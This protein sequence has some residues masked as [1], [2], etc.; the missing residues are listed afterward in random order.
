MRKRTLGF[1]RVGL[2]AY[3]QHAAL[4]HGVAG[5]GAEIHCDL[6]QLR[7]VSDDVNGR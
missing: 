1:N 3:P 7:R 5:V 2:Q 6:V 4:R